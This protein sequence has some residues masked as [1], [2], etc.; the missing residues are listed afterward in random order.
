MFIHFFPDIAYLADTSLH[1]VRA[2]AEFLLSVFWL[3]N[4]NVVYSALIVC[5]RETGEF[6]SWNIE[7]I[8]EDEI[9]CVCVCGLH[10]YSSVCAC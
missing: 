5:D 3:A 6:S 4:E 9:E 10:M 2:W 1:W 8:W 7:L